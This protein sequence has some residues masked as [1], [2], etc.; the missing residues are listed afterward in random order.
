MNE[1]WNGDDDIVKLIVTAVPPTWYGIQSKSEA[2]KLVII[3]TLLI[4]K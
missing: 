4:D 3:G 2:E 1:I